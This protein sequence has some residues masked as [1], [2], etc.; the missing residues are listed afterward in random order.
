MRDARK[1]EVLLSESAALGSYGLMLLRHGFFADLLR[2]R[3]TVFFS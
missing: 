3:C 2:E 1:P